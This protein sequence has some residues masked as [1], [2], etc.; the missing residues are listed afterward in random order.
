M[1]P[2]T[3]I[4]DEKLIY[5][6]NDFIGF[7]KGIISIQEQSRKEVLISLPPDPNLFF[8]KSPMQIHTRKTIL[9]RT[10]TY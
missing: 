10:L 9:R 2:K 1:T 4:E 5:I 3:K 7:D 8:F 6:K